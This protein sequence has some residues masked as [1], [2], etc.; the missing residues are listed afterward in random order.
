MS[1]SMFRSVAIL[2]CLFIHL[3]AMG[4]SSEIGITL[5][6]ST[7]KGDLKLP[8]LQPN[9]TIWLV[10]FYLGIATAITGRIK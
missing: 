6:T 2:F 3:I 10:V 4:Q 7:Y 8:C 1:L 9:T 5:G